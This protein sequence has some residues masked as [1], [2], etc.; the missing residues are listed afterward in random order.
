MRDRKGMDQDRKEVGEDFGGEKKTETTT[1]IYCIRRQS[2][3]NKRG[4]VEK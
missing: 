2:V 4:K 1:I 3:F